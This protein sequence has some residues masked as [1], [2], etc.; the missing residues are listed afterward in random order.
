VQNCS[1]CGGR[2]YVRDKVLVTQLIADWQL[3]HAEATYID[4]QQG[5]HCIVCGANLRVVALGVAVAAAFGIRVPLRDLVQRHEAERF[6]LLDI[7]GAVAISLTLAALPG[8]VRCGFPAV[9]IHHLPYQNASFDIVIHS[10]TL[11]HV[12]QPVRAL[13]ECRRVLAPGGRLCFTVPTIVGRLTRNREGLPKS[14]HGDPSVKLDDYLVYTEFGADVWCYVMQAGFTH[15]AI[16]QVAYPA[17]TA[18]SA[19]CEQGFLGGGDKVA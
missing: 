5:C 6:R 11:E 19:W 7:N 1:I 2:N 15:L 4:D 16:N 9:D 12:S 13:E 8:Y 10:D 18:I 17:A 14:Y 3:S